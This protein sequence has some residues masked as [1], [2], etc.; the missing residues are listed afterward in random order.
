MIKG[1]WAYAAES[2]KDRDNALHK[3]EATRGQKKLL[4]KDLKLHDDIRQIFAVRRIYTVADQ[5]FIGESYEPILN[6]SRQSKRR[7]LKMVKFVLAKS[8]ERLPANRNH[9]VLL[10]H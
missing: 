4:Q 7:W 5:R 9:G 3:V 10:L 8:H 1:L 6:W 2:W